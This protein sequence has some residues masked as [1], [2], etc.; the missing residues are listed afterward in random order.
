MNESA[1]KKEKFE[2]PLGASTLANIEVAIGRGFEIAAVVLLRPSPS[3]ESGRYLFI[4]NTAADP[5]VWAGF[6]EELEA[7]GFPQG[8]PDWSRQ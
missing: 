2:V 6:S 4:T 5:E 8:A 7:R 1:T 3:R